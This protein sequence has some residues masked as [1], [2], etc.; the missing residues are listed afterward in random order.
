MPVCE[1]NGA[2]TLTA[3]NTFGANGLVSRTEGGSTVYYSFDPQGSVAQRHDST[4]AALTTYLWD[5][6]GV[7]QL[8]GQAN[9]QPWGYGAQHGYTTDRSNASDT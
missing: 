6:Y 9:N 1:F 8:S 2:G 5:P 7:G 3:T 4:G